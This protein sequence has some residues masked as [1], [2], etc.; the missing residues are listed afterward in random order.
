MCKSLKCPTSGCCGLAQVNTNVDLCHDFVYL[1]SNWND[2][3]A[4]YS[5]W[6][7]FCKRVISATPHNI[8]KVSIATEV[9][10]CPRI[11]HFG[12]IVKKLL[13]SNFTF[14]NGHWE[15]VSGGKQLNLF[16]GSFCC[17]TLSK[18]IKK[19]WKFRGHTNTFHISLF[20]HP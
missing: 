9:S 7:I 15:H 3:L 2:I 1:L 4:I 5:K 8:A 10:F 16:C 12:K 11:H 13:F 17:Y 6:Y 18:Q 20:K 19:T 14:S